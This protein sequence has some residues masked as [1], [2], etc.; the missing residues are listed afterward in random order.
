VA[1]RVPRGAW[2]RPPAWLLLFGGSAALAALGDEPPLVPVLGVTVSLGGLSQAALFLGIT[3]VSVVGATVLVWT[4]P[5]GAVPPLLQHLTRWGRRVRLPLEQWT[6]AI[7]LGLR[8]APMLLDD[9]RTIL[10][11]AGQ[12]RRSRPDGR[13]PWR[14]RLGRLAHGA[15]LACA[16]AS[17]RAAET[18]EAVAARGG[19]GVIAGPEGRP[20]PR[21][22]LAAL[23]VAGVLTAGSLL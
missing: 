21:D 11:L 19:I 14:E 15:T 1:G 20:G 3:L 2:P 5:V 10:Q 22:A 16:T 18:G 12:R 4:T 9:S 8:M 6:A 17:R 23:L 7:A 13:E